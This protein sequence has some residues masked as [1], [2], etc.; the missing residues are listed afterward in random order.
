M[1][2]SLALRLARVSLLPTV[3]TNVL[4]GVALAGGDWRDPR[5][6]A[7]LLAAS[8]AYTAGMFLNDAFDRGFDALAR[9]DRPIP[10]GQVSARQVFAYGFGLLAASVLVFAAVGLAAD[11]PR[12]EVGL[13]GLLLAA[14]IVLYDAHHKRNPASPLVMGACRMLVYVSAALAISPQPG[15]GLW[16]GAT[17]LLCYL[18]GLTYAAKTEQLARLDRV[19]PLALLVVPLLYALA[20]ASAQPAILLPAALGSLWTGS[21]VRRLFR[22][23]AGDVPA[24]VGALLAGISIVDAI[25]LAGCGQLALSLVAL[26]LVALT[27]RLQRWVQGT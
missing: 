23:A 3:W 1:R 24:A 22:R 20:M 7:V 6:A 17:V 5:V 14:L 4:A 15:P 12:Q 2:L 21:A 27:M 19:W 18:I 26:A 11:P 10:A 16:L 13:A 25:V 8:L 9:P